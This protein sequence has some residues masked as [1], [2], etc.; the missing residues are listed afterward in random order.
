MGAELRGVT[1]SSGD[2]KL[3]GAPV[4]AEPLNSGNFEEHYASGDSH[5]RQSGDWI[6]SVTCNAN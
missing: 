1:R 4:A 2:I 6:W 3:W 5:E